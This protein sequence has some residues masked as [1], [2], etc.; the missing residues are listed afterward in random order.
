[1]P[2]GAKYLGWI[3]YCWEWLERFSKIHISF[4]EDAAGW[5]KVKEIATR[6]GNA[7][8]DSM[9]VRARA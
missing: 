7:R 6:L 2:G 1:M 8:A 9:S 4:D 5:A 3:D